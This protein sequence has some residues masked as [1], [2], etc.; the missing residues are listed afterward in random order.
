[1]ID[2]K[3]SFQ[4]LIRVTLPWQPFVPI[5]W[6]VHTGFAAER[7]R[8][9]TTKELKCNTRGRTSM[10]FVD[11]ANRPCPAKSIC[12]FTIC[13]VGFACDGIRQEVLG[14]IG[15]SLCLLTYTITI[16]RTVVVSVNSLKKVQVLR[17]TQAY[18]LTDKLTISNRRWVDKRVDCRQVLPCI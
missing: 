18:Q 2:V 16:F 7:H 11:H 6:I 12:A 1:M 8:Q 4:S 17:W 3:F 9:R 14:D 10:S 15:T 5:V 13:S